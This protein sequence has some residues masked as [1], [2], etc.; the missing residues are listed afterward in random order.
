MVHQ[1][2]IV[3]GPGPQGCYMRWSFDRAGPWH[4]GVG[5]GG[6]AREPDHQLFGDTCYLYNIQWNSNKVSQLLH[7]S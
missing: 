1:G 5:G 3:H 2:S 4:G 6:G 7:F